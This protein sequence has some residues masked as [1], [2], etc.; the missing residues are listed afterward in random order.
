MN[1]AHGTFRALMVAPIA[2]LLLATPAFSQTPEPASTL[3]SSV[4]RWVHSV[5]ND[6]TFVTPVDR[7]R[8]TISFAA[9]GTFSA[10]ADC[11]QLSGTYRQLG[12]RLTLQMGPMTLAA[13]PPGSKADDFV[14]QLGAVVS[15]AGTDTALVLNLRQDSGSMVFEAQPVPSLTDTVWQVQSYNNGRGG[16]TTLLA[17][18][19]MSALFGDD[20]TISGSSGCNTYSGMY[21]VDNTSISIGPLVTTRIECAPDVMQQEQAFLAALQA[22]TEYQL[23][24]GLLTMR[25]DD[26]ATQVNFMP[27]PQE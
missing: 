9:G 13:C 24:P 12:R 17:D 18:T 10:R 6:D 27:P 21:A 19:S 3:Q 20:G 7:D 2:T 1:A 22:T 26:G 15:Q 25:N 23:V 5:V 16:V 4:W 8:Y 14:Q 11:N